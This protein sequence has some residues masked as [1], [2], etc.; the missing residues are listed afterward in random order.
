M[1]HVH[2]FWQITIK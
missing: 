1:L 2:I